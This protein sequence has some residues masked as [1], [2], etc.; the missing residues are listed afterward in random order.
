MRGGSWSPLRLRPYAIPLGCAAVAIAALLTVW[1]MRSDDG[2]VGRDVG[3]GGNVFAKE[4]DPA[5]DAGG[6]TA[7]EDAASQDAELLNSWLSGVVDLED[8]SSIASSVDSFL[9]DLSKV[10]GPG[11]PSG[12][13]RAPTHGVHWVE[14]DDVPMAAKGVLQAYAKAG[15]AEL[16]AS[17]YLDM[18]GNVW[19]AIVQGGSA[20][21][22]VVLVSTEGGSKSTVRVVRTFAGAV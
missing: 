17:G 5:V 9:Q 11:G 20:W 13:G 2:S 3:E 6:P 8:D 10:E 12:D 15:G 14:R 7:S 22:D 1:C 18:R 4:S 21:C 19:G 16:A